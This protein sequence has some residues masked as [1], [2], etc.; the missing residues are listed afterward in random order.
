VGSLA[1]WRLLVT[2]DVLPDELEA[3]NLYQTIPS[4][5]LNNAG[6]NCHAVFDIASFTSEVR[7][8][9]TARCTQAANYRQLILIG[10]GGTTFWQALQAIGRDLT[11]NET[12]HPVDEFTVAT[13]QQFLQTE[14]AGI[15]FEIVYPGSYTISLQELGKLAG[16]HHPSPFMV[17]INSSFGSWFAYRAVVLANTDLPANLTVQTESPCTSCNEK[18]CISNC[19]AH[20]LD[21]GQFHLLKCVSY[22]Q[23]SDSLCKNTCIARTSCPVASEHK[24][25]EAQINYHYGRSMEVID[26]LKARKE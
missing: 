24:Y 21:D 25:S 11:R 19:P 1:E 23:Q 17:G 14:F 16:W 9:L 6:L 4:T 12:E 5:I 2:I 3:M 15:D 13:V 10:H 20:A 18:P 22:R 26:G 8:L 7:E